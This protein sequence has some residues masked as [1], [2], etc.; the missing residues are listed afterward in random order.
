MNLLYQYTPKWVSA[1]PYKDCKDIISPTVL[2]FYLPTTQ[3]IL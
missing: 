1:T 3:I 2:G